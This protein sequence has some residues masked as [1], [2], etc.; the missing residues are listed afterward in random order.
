M[1]WPWLHSGSDLDTAAELLTKVVQQAV[2]DA[3]PWA[4]PSQWA[5]PG[6]T[7]ECREALRSTKAVR[8]RWRSTR[9]EWDWADYRWKEQA[10]AHCIRRAIT[11]EFWKAVRDT[12]SKLVG[13]W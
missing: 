8:G 4:Q 11:T 7:Q 12:T 5:C 13:L 2:E 6:W 10:K 1:D 3:T 9:T